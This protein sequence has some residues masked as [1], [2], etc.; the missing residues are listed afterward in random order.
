MGAITGAILKRNQNELK[1]YEQYPK[2]IKSKHTKFQNKIQRITIL[3]KNP[4]LTK[5]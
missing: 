1:I 4:K 5:K 2:I 3:T